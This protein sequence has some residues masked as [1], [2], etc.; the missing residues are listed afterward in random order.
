V[1]TVGPRPPI[2]TLTP[3]D[4]DA[5][6]EVA[7]ADAQIRTLF[8]GQQFEVVN[9]A[10]WTASMNLEKIGVVL[11]FDFPTPFTVAGTW[12]IICYNDPPYPPR[13]YVRGDW[14]RTIR[15]LRTALVFVDLRYREVV[16]IEPTPRGAAGFDFLGPPSLTELCVPKPGG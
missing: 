15:D 1:G 13:F 10:M 16:Q 7:L 12:P 5:A 14:Q 4:V 3:E 6:R 9:P 2:P 11:T 8:A